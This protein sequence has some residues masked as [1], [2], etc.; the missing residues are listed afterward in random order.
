MS[1]ANSNFEE[2]SIANKSLKIQDFAFSLDKMSLDGAL[3]DIDKLN[4]FSKEFIAKEPAKELEPK[5]MGGFL[6]NKKGVINDGKMEFFA[7]SEG[8]FNGLTHY[9][10]HH[11]VAVISSDCFLLKTSEPGPWCLDGEKGPEGQI[12]ITCHPKALRI[13]SKKIN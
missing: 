11:K 7:A 10:F 6:V 2:W 9:L 4:Y 13:F 5:V 12:L 1:I 8:P 3:F